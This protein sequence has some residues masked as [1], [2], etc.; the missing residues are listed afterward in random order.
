[1]CMHFSLVGCG[2]ERRSDSGVCGHCHMR[3][4]WVSHTLTHTDTHTL[5]FSLSLSLSLS[6]THTHTHIYPRIHGLET[7]TNID[8]FWLFAPSAVMLAK[9]LWNDEMCYECLCLMRYN[10][11]SYMGCNIMCDAAVFSIVMCIWSLGQ[12]RSQAVKFR[13]QCG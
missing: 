2:C 8:F 11:G 13:Q 3:N 4:E 1:M 5:S 7:P 12:R 10:L 6:H 9:C